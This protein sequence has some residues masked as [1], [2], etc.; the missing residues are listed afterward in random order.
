MDCICTTS[1]G[2]LGRKD[3]SETT[4][5]VSQRKS[6]FNNSASGLLSAD[7]KSAKVLI[8]VGPISVAKVIHL[9][10]QLMWVSVGQKS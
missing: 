4:T 8:Y 7:T 5:T 6:I 2:I 9:S 1:N 3:V 10:S